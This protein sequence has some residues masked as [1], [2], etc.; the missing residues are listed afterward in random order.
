MFELK[1]LN[2]HRIVETEE[3]KQRLIAKG[4]KEVAELPFPYDKLTLKQLKELA[5]ERGL[6]GYSDLKKD[7]LITA[8]KEAEAPKTASE[9]GELNATPSQTTNSE[10]KDA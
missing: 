2:V 8:L 5:K 3:E 7:E 6:S 10:G 9:G 4:F 1:K